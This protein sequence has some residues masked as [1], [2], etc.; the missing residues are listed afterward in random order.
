MTL[1]NLEVCIYVA[2]QV[3]SCLSSL[4]SSHSMLALRSSTEASSEGL[5]QDRQVSQAQIQIFGDVNSLLEVVTCLYSLKMEPKA[6][7]LL[8]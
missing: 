5:N 2:R 6:T 7:I 3:G 1:K 4:R 8:M